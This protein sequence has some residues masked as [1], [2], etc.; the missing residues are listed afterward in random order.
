[1][2]LVL[3]VVSDVVYLDRSR[4]R[5][6]DCVREVLRDFPDVV[7]T[8]VL[9]VP[10]DVAEIRRAVVEGCR[11]GDVVVVC[12]GTGV[13]VWDVSVEAVKPLFD[14]ELSGF[15]EYFRYVS[16]RQV[17]ARAVLSRAVAGV[18]GNSIV[19][20]IPGS[21]EAVSLALREIIIEISRHI[22]DLLRGVKHWEIGNCIVFVRDR[23]RVQDLLAVNRVVYSLTRGSGCVV[24]FTGVVKE[25]VGERIVKSLRVEIDVKEFENFCRKLA[26]ERRCS[27][28]AALSLGE[29]MPGDF[30]IHVA[31]IAESRQVG[32]SVL[33][34][35]VEFY[36]SKGIKKEIVV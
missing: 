27:I 16:L 22:L 23:L 14:R 7:L 29:L 32:F 36:K 24:S 10:N 9:Y 31:V 4:D 28:V 11:L 5:V 21:P 19:Y 34:E 6:A 20:V 25:R 2:K 1:M 17:G 12:G 26:S 8:E 35:I 30:I 33:R 18:V 3:V 13:G 15:G